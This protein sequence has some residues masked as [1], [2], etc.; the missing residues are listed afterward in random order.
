MRR[1]CPGD[2]IASVH[3]SLNHLDSSG[4][5]GF[6]GES[7]TILRELPGVARNRCGVYHARSS[8][9]V[10]ADTMRFVTLQPDRDRAEILNRTVDQTPIKPRRLEGWLPTSS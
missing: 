6:S 1:R 2:P 5:T 10:I 4:T 7:Q 3:E 8:A 9:G